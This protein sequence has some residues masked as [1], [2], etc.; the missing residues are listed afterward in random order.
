ME[1][2]DPG[3]GRL[4]GHRVTLP[5]GFFEY[6]K[7][8]KDTVFFCT[9]HNELNGYLEMT[10][11]VADNSINERWSDDGVEIY[12]HGER[13]QKLSEALEVASKILGEAI[14]RIEKLI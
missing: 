10:P 12:K 5:D 11:A 6:W 3:E 9:I 8:P 1:Q 13:D 2:K 14:E 7:I 4:F